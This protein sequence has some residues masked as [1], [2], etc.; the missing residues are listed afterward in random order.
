MKILSLST[1]ENGCSL[2]IMDGRK[3]VC[4][5]LWTS[6]KT[7]SKRIMGMID[8]LLSERAKMSIEDIDG[9]VAAKGPG[10]F[11]GL[12]IGI[13]VVK[14][15]AVA[16]GKPEYGVSSLDGIAF[17]FFTASCPVC[18]MMDARRD[19]VYSSVY[20][21]E[22]GRLVSRTPEKVDHPLTLL[23][24]HEGPVLFAGSGAKVYEDLIRDNVKEP[25][26]AGQSVENVSAKAMVKVLYDTPDFQ[27]SQ[28]FFLVPDYI[29]KSD[30]ELA[31]GQ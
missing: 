24:D 7:H 30:A 29:R 1:A 17:Q 13:S 31:F 25:F 15:F 19:Q 3:L 12:R 20:L 8:H 16:L 11:T 14:G 10:S 22:K 5:E 21:F 26:F 9:F 28:K 4:E 27:N 2:A 18:V 23:P 6:R